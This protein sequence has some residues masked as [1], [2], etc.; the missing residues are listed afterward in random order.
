[1]TTF[2]DE[3][4]TKII[5]LINL[6]FR[7]NDIIIDNN[8]ICYLNRSIKIK[9]IFK[10]WTWIPNKHTGHNTDNI[11]YICKNYDK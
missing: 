4:E 10:F 11:Q 5:G 9:S 1:M 6:I 8:S 7:R 3:I 2:V